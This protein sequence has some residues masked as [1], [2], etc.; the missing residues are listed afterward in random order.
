MKIP[1]TVQLVKELRRTLS[2][3]SLCAIVEDQLRSRLTPDNFS[4]RMLSSE[5]AWKSICVHAAIVMKELRRAERERKKVNLPQDQ[6][7]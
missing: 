4:Q 1:R 6:A 3:H 5:T 7:E 2:M